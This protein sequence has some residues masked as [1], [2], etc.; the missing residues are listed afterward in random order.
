MLVVELLVPGD[1]PDVHPPERPDAAVGRQERPSVLD[2]ERR[3]LPA[4]IA[5]EIRRL[6]KSIDKICRWK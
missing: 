3:A 4:E 2:H 5:A 1:V 6:I